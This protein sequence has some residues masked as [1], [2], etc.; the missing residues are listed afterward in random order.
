MAEERDFTV[1]NRNWR[2]RLVIRKNFSP[3][4]TLAVQQVAQRN[5][6]VSVLRGF[7]DLTGQSPEQPGAADPVLGGG[8]VP[9]F[10]P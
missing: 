1:I 8:A 6:A 7:Q 5:C 10:P 4:D 9:S 2:F 3:E